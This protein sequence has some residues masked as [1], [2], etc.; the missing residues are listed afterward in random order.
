MMLGLHLVRLTR[1]I[2]RD[3]REGLE[4]LLKAL[5]H[6]MKDNYGRPYFVCSDPDNSS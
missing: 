3:P 6:K 4:H 5:E 1:V 2:L